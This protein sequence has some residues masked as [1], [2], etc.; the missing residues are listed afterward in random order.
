[1]TGRCAKVTTCFCSS[2]VAL[3]AKS[4][5]YVRHFQEVHH[6]I[7]DYDAASPV[8][9]CDIAINGPVSLRGEQAVRCFAGICRRS[10]LERRQ[11]QCARAWMG[12]DKHGR[13]LSAG[14][15]SSGV[16]NPGLACHERGRVCAIDLLVFLSSTPSYPERDRQRC[17]DSGR[18]RLPS[19]AAS[20]VSL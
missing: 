6:D 3:K 17:R 13:P 5:E 12:S 8:V 4:G 1:M 15:S 20:S 11:I 19:A 16:R 9:L 18:S 10:S 14:R 2:I 7:W